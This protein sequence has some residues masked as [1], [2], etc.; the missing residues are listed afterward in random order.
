MATPAD[1]APLTRE[2]VAA[3]LRTRRLGHGLQI[4]QETTST[5]SEAANLAQLGMEHGT[6]VVAEQQTEGKGRLG[7]RWH[8]P[9]AGNLYCSVILKVST[10]LRQSP[11]WLSWIP[12]VSAVAATRAVQSVTGLQPMVKWPNDL[13]LDGRKVGGVLCE[14]G[15]AG[16]QHLYV[17]V[18]IG[19]NVNA[20]R[21]TFPE[22][23]QTIATSLV[24]ETGHTIDRAMLLASLLFEL[25]RR[26]D[27]LLDGVND[28]PSDLVKEYTVLCSTLGQKVRVSLAD[29]ECVEGVA[30][31][32][33]AD[34][35][36]RIICD[37]G[38]GGGTVDLRAG[39]VVHLR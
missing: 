33:V 24:S 6:V 26:V 38:S 1:S 29:G 16:R 31:S 5:N 21:E 32:I 14:S 22:D 37:Q 35:S 4:L 10:S 2:A 11:T 39:D 13:L 30:D 17:V 8:S 36:L 7:R 23:L 15:V 28:I 18:G 34:G 25:E 27:S 20:S 12:L 3:C 19:L 9:A